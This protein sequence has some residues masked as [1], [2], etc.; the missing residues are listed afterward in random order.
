MNRINKL[1]SGEYSV[2]EFSDAYYMYQLEEVPDDALSEAE[3]DFFSYVRE[4]L[5]WTDQNPDEA[6][7]K[8]GWKDEKEY[9]ELVRRNLLS[10][11]SD[12]DEW[13]KSYEDSWGKNTV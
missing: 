3:D 12:E 4:Q 13:H 7:R 8:D 1:L 9:I 6:S 2:S 10:F 11:L 5:D